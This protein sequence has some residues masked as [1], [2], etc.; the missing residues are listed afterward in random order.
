MTEPMIRDVSDTAFMVAAYR[1]AESERPDALFHDPLARR[2]AGERGRRIAAQAAGSFFGGWTVVIRTCLIDDFIREAVARGTGAVLNLG[3]GLDTRPYRM[4]LPESLHWIEVDLPHVVELKEAELAGETP[5]C[6]LERV[7]LDLSDRPARER[8]FASL[9][10]RF[11]EVLVLTEGLIPY[12]TTD[13]VGALA[14]D[15]R[16][17]GSLSSWLVDYFSPQVIQYRKKTP[18]QKQMENAPFRFEPSDYFGFFREHGWSCRE[19]RYIPDEARRLKRAMPL[20][21]PLKV[22]LKLRALFTPPARRDVFRRYA[23]YVLLERCEPKGIVPGQGD[24][25]PLA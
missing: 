12:L 11:R 13:Q 22:I 18:L 20:P 8:L 4:A 19:V 3:A 6:R 5:R 2:L 16:A 25:S 10:A 24:F 15:L 14:D 17:H 23:G 7:K 21:L 9:S 1:A